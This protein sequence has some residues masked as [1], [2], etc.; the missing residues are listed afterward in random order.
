MTVGTEVHLQGVGPPQQQVLP[1]KK[2]AVR[3]GN[4]VLFLVQDH[5]PTIDEKEKALQRAFQ[6]LRPSGL[7]ALLLVGLLVAVGCY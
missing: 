7:R 2:L 1:H 5:T 4:Q 3:A 6:R